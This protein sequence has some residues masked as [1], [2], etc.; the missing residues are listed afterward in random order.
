[1]TE[2]L[3]IHFIIFIS[4]NQ[5]LLKARQN[6][7]LPSSPFNAKFAHIINKNAP[8]RL[9]L[10]TCP[11]IN[12]FEC[13]NVVQASYGVAICMKCDLSS[14]LCP[15]SLTQENLPTIFKD[16]QMISSEITI[17]TKTTLTKQKDSMSKEKYSTT[18][19]IGS[20]EELESNYFHTSSTSI[21]KNSEN[22]A[23]LIMGISL[24]SVVFLVLIVGVLIIVLMR[25]QR[26][27]KNLRKQKENLELDLKLKQTLTA[28]NT[29]AI[30]TT[31]TSSLTP[32]QDFFHG[33]E[34]QTS[35]PSQPI[36]PDSQNESNNPSDDVDV[37]L[38]V[39]ENNL[40]SS[41][42]LPNN[43]SND[44]LPTYNSLFIQLSDS[45]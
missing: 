16:G 44:K 38:N 45:I 40:I 34:M 12:S 29:A 37:Y 3:A 9:L 1:M 43:H 36:T 26:K 42:C 18:S 28:A 17:G 13:Q 8:L 2:N 27:A 11:K 32:L 41:D 33:T 5:Y 4:C 20:E 7:P 14:K 10:K 31:P 19:D 6:L 35:A 22:R 21:N 23:G 24:T 15:C 25:N 39:D 30:A